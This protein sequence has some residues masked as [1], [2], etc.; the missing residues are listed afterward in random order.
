MKFIIERELLLKP[1]QQVISPL[2]ARPAL[3]IL[4]NL[5]LEVKEGNLILTGTDLEME[6]MVCLPLKREYH[7][8]A[9]TIPGRKFFD[10][11]RNL[12][13]NVEITV[14]LEDTRI[15]V[16]SGRSRFSLL[17]LPS[18]SFPNLEDWKSEV[19]FSVPQVVI[20]RLIDATQFSM[21]HQD[22][23]Y[24]LNGMLFET[25]GEILRTVSTDGHRLAICSMSVEK[26]LPNYSVI[27]PRKGV[28]ELARL[29]DG[30][31]GLLH[32]QMGRN[33]IR[34]HSGNFI[35]TS[36]L[37]DGRFPDYRRVLPNNPDKILRA[38]CNLLKQSLSRVAVL[39][40][41]KVRAV[42]LYISLNN[43]KITANNPEEEEAEEILDALYSGSDFEIG[44]NVSYVLDALNALKC[45]NVRILLT[46]SISSIQIEDMTS[47]SASYVIM[48]MRL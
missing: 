31:K 41:E 34:V 24:Y 29:L 39:S 6:M 4:S 37:V 20:K 46:D 2:A 1:L 5:L 33:N 36:K 19:E 43:I 13:E 27:V 18:S 30:R 45:Q 10:I 38:D 26:I 14:M 47:P 32:V 25:S 22:V 9:I 17:T 48:P 21:A 40:N 15:L 28:I 16:Q 11:C 35:F 12:P 44:L 23:R 8:G 7:M 42:R 3:P